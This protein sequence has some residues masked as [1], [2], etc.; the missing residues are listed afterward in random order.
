MNLKKIGKEGLIKRAAD[1]SV[2]VMVKGVGYVADLPGVS[3]LNPEAAEGE[4]VYTKVFK[5]KPIYLPH[6]Y[7]R[8][9]REILKG[10][11]VVVLGMNGYSSLTEQKCREWGVRPGAYEAAC[12]GI[13][14]RVIAEL[15]A[16]YPGVDVR[17]AHGAS[18]M[19]VDGVILGVAAKLNKRQLGHSCPR[20]MFYV[21]DDEVPV[22][23]GKTQV[24]YA[25]A[26]IDSLDVLVAANGREQ[27]FRHDINAVFD[28][29]KHVIPVN[30]L[31][32]ISTT[33]GPPALNGDGKIEDAVAYFEQRVHL[34]YR[35]FTGTGDPFRDIVNHVIEEGRQISRL[36]ISPNR[37]FSAESVASLR[38]S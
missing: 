7:D 1:G 12:A 30:V 38:N 13:L 3:C 26:F 21:E 10:T 27:A 31:R 16:S 29:G 17:L 18:G 8:A 25:N 36:L 33:G 11:D 19:G 23:V 22:Y 6:E 9:V 35:A 24:D 37:A 34:M 32:S 5:R 28:K 14:E 15:E 20:F 4:R 2:T